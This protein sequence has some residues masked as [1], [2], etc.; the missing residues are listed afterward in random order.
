M[1]SK[2]QI[3]EFCQKRGLSMPKYLTTRLPSPAHQ[4]EFVSKLAFNNSTFEGEIASS[5][6]R[7]ELSAAEIA[8]QSLEEEKITQQIVYDGPPVLILVDLENQP[9]AVEQLQERINLDASTNI[10]ILV[11]VSK[12]SHLSEQVWDNERIKKHIVPSVRSDAADTYMIF[13][14]GLWST[15]LS[16]R[17]FI[18]MSRDHFA[19]TL[20]EIFHYH[21][22]EAIMECQIDR[23]IDY[24]QK[25]QD[26]WNQ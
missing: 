22:K 21:K 20:E 3:Q 13:M 6:R 14:A 23:I 17:N 8:L 12:I 24:L 4:P 11:F 2:N 26:Q 19:K 10:Y 15:D 9:R 18:I 25:V 16:Y 5:K 7:A 1:S